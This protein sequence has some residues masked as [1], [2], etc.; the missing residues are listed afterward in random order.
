MNAWTTSWSLLDQEGNQIEDDGVLPSDPN[1]PPI[2]HTPYINELA[3]DSW[4]QAGARIAKY[5]MEIG[6]SGSNMNNDM[7]IYRYADVHE[8][9]S[10]MANESK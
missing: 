4:R 5:E 2:T 3:P 8:S 7:V 9:R 6:L 1:G 10:I